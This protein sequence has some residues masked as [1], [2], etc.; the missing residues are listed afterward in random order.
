MGVPDISKTQIDAMADQIAEAL[1]PEWHRVPVEIRHASV[2]ADDKGHAFSIN[3][4]LGGP[5][6]LRVSGHYEG[7]LGQYA[8]I[9]VDGTKSP[10]PTIRVSHSKTAAV[11]AAEIVRRFLPQLVEV[12]DAAMAHKTAVDTAQA[13]AE[14][15]A[16]QL[17]AIAPGATVEGKN[18]N[19]VIYVPDEAGRPSFSAMCSP[20]SVQL[21]LRSL[22][23]AKAK[24][25]LQL[26]MQPE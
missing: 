19:Q 24:A 16:E 3:A 5:G 7:D 13:A 9:H 11:I 14:S 10:L 15:V 18:Q 25:V 26:L 21:D 1:G 12:T 22:S 17:A 4:A 20:G 8:Q 2:L 6:Q 23:T